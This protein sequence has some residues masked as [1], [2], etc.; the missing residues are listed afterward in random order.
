MTTA[1]VFF[2]VCFLIALRYTWTR[3]AGQPSITMLL[4]AALLVI[5]GIPMLV[6]MHLTGPDTF[7]YETAL[8]SLDQDAVFARLL[9]ALGLTFIGVVAGSAATRMVWSSIRPQHTA[10]ASQGKASLRNVYGLT[11]PVRLGLWILALGVLAV[12]VME[13]QPAKIAAYFLSG[14]SEMDR[15]YMRIDGGGTGIY[16]YNVF[17]YSLAPFVVM[18]LWCIKRAR[19]ADSEVKLLFFTFFGLVLLGKMGTLSKAPPVIFLL[20]MA[21][22]AAILSHVS[23]RFKDTLRLGTLVILLFGLVVNFTFP[24]LDLSGILQFL[25]Y[26]IF[27]IPNEGLIEYFAAFPASLRHNWEYGMFGSLHRGE[28][29]LPNYFAV[30]E[31]SRGSI[32]STSNVMFIGDAWADYEWFGVVAFPFLAGVMVQAVDLYARRNGRTDEWACITAAC[33]FSVFTMLSTALPTALLTG[34]LALIP[35]ASMLFLR[36]SRVRGAAP[37]ILSREIQR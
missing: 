34:G 22:L 32:L 6:Y 26:R 4:L 35:V 8:N 9:W 10:A 5:H 23:V 21:F 3:L 14:G 19:P 13:G 24:D 29:P 36:T 37:T 17:L 18:V 1:T 33:S 30:A 20:Q 15:L 25:Y 7:I 31:L 27:D 28:V 12:I 11:L 16:A 2:C